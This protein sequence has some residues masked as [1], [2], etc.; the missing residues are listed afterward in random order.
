MES[1]RL[2]PLSP[3][4]AIVGYLAGGAIQTLSLSLINLI[5]GA[6]IF[7][8]RGVPVQDW[9]ISNALLF[10]FSVSLWT[11]MAMAAFVSRS[12]FGWVISLLIGITSSGGFIFL[13]V[14]GLLAFCSPMQGRTIFEITSLPKLSGGT[15][16]AF[17]AQFLV[18]IL[19]IRGAARKY[20]DASAVSFTMAPALAM[21]GIWAGLN[22]YGITDF[23]DLRPQ[24]PWASAGSILRVGQFDWRLPIIGAVA[25]SLL[26]ALVP[27]A[28]MVWSGISRQQRRMD[29]QKL[30]LRP[31]M[32]ALCMAISLLFVLAPLTAI[33]AA[34]IIAPQRRYVIP[35]LP[36]LTSTRRSQGAIAALSR[37]VNARPPTPISI[38]MIRNTIRP[39]LFAAVCAIFLMDMYLLMRLF[40]PIFRR[41]NALILL[42]IGLSW[43][44]P[45][46]ADVIYYGMRDKTPAMDKFA[47]YSPIGTMVQA[48]GNAVAGTWR[49]VGMQAAACGFL[50]VIFILVR[51]GRS[52][53][54]PA[55]IGLT[56]DL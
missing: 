12:I 37:Y 34:Y 3:V 52:R 49:G 23:R 18:V 9:L 2:M 46:F 15:I 22:W 1:H 19:C 35:R 6:M 21:L 8:A 13:I 48:L 25:S 40:Y 42:I 45:L 51:L 11:A 50:A 43:F 5:L 10:G 39:N 26:V 16:V 44:G 47:L 33:R 56:A 28:A 38:P 27:L 24:P 4:Q 7:A 31:W 54:R 55:P 20:A 14:P 32:P 41:P 29:G 36:S 30:P 17:G 53:M